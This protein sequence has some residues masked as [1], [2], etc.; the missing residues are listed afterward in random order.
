MTAVGFVDALRI[1]YQYYLSRWGQTIKHRG[2]LSELPS[3]TALT[4]IER[5]FSDLALFQTG[6]EKSL[7][8]SFL[9][10]RMLLTYIYFNDI[11]LSI[12]K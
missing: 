9:S 2:H 8:C 1:K 7:S 3:L 5:R 11:C 4:Y 12:R 10:T 6:M